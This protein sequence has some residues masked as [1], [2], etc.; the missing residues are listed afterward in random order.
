MQDENC[1]YI[2]IFVYSASPKKVVQQPNPQHAQQ[3]TVQRWETRPAFEPARPTLGLEASKGVSPRA[4]LTCKY[5]GSAT[6]QQTSMGV[7]ASLALGQNTL[8][9]NR[10]RAS[11]S[12]SAQEFW[13]R[14]HTASVAW[15][16]LDWCDDRLQQTVDLRGTAARAAAGGCGH[17]QR[18]DLVHRC[19]GQE[20]PVRHPGAAVS[21][22]QLPSIPT[23][24]MA[25]SCGKPNPTRSTQ[26]IPVRSLEKYADPSAVVGDNLSHEPERTH[27]P[28]RVVGK[29]WADHGQTSA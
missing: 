21:C 5:G 1:C 14:G 22:G 20:L 26:R 15:S 24:T 9:N 4:S 11:N 2:T 12:I 8:R 3:P 13:A 27:K 6:G 28:R 23:R 7:L 29:K 25:C 10:F 17:G 18:W 19:S 16:V